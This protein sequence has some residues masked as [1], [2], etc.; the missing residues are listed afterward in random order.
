MY[1]DETTLCCSLNNTPHIDTLNRELHKINIWLAR[2]KLLLNVDKTK[3][4]IFHTK[5]RTI[6]SPYIQV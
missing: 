5:Q 1:A 6:T 2:N 3:V 4:M